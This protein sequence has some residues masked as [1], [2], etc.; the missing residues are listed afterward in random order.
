MSESLIGVFTTSPPSSNCSQSDF[1]ASTAR[2]AQWSE[3]YGC[4]G[5]LVY[6]DNSMVDPW[7]VSEIILQ[8][9]KKLCPLVAV[10]PVY[11]HPYTVAKMATTLA[12]LHGRRIYLNMVAGG[13]KNDLSA[14]DDA[15]P[16]DERYLRLVEYTTIIKRLLSSRAEISY[17]G[18]YY[19]IK[20]LKMTPPLPPGLMP[21]IFVS[22]SSDAGLAAARAMEATAIMY[23]RPALEC[24]H[25]TLPSD[26][27]CGIRVG[28]I[29]RPDD[30]EAWS[31]ARQRFPGDRRGQLTHQLTMK[32]SDS[33][34]HKHLSN[35]ADENSGNN[36]TYWLWPFQNYKTF[37]P[38]L[39]GSHKRVVDEI[40]RYVA[41]G[42]RTF[43]VDVP[44]FEEDLFHTSAVFE[45]VSQRVCQSHGEDATS[46]QPPRPPQYGHTHSAIKVS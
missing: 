7:L 38:Y 23:P 19:R 45:K 35:L 17:E 46:I 13:F 36:E 44:L 34:W 11:M 12:F 37:C 39:V 32:T 18:K 41:L 20:N 9:T 28:I 26:I 31:V 43:I 8:N 14:L 1:A 25:T 4:T 40:S 42:N 10:Q 21:G 24:E 33:V 6:T 15:T 27:P 3:K 2:V 29:A 16:H 30:E 22:G 5:T